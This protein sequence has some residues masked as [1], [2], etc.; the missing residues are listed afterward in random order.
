MPLIPS[1]RSFKTYRTLLPETPGRRLEGSQSRM[2]LNCCT[3]RHALMKVLERGSLVLSIIFFVRQLKKSFCLS[4]VISLDVDG[5]W[6]ENI[7]PL[8][9]ICIFH[10]FSGFSL[11]WKASLLLRS[12]RGKGTHESHVPYQRL[13]SLPRDGRHTIGSF[14]ICP[15]QPR[16]L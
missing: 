6:L 11:G 13:S 5:D 3:A 12:A 2:M 4:S 14:A 1:L 9:D 15:W 7:S 8:L 16:W 10:G